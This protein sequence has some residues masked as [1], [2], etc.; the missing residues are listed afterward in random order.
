MEKIDMIGALY[1]LGAMGI[2]FA[3]VANW[4]KDKS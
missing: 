4:I 3:L 2:V 1:M